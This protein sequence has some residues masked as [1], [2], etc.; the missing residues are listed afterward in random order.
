MESYIKAF[1]YA[2]EA[3]VMAWV[4]S[5]WRSYAFR[6]MVGLLNATLGAKKK[7]AIK[8]LITQ[9]HTHRESRENHILPQKS[10]FLKA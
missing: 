8:T 3:D 7:K 9:V 4:Q 1:Y 5:Q 2:G 10:R 6:H